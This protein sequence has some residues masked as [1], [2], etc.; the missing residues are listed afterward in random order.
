MEQQ[1]FYRKIV[2]TG[3]LHNV[4]AGQVQLIKR[5]LKLPVFIPPE[6]DPSLV[7]LRERGG[8][9]LPEVKLYGFSGHGIMP[10]A[11]LKF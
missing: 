8:K 2:G 1:F 6:D 3:E 7:E 4:H 10:P 11:L 5:R 9:T